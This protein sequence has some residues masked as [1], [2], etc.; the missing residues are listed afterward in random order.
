MSIGE[1]LKYADVAFSMIAS[2]K[3]DISAVSR[4]DRLL[5]T[6]CYLFATRDAATGGLVK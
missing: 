6:A 3:E 1:A 4:L 5:N 2:A